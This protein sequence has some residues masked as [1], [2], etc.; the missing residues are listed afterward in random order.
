MKRNSLLT[1]VSFAMTALLSFAA[2]PFVAALDGAEGKEYDTFDTGRGELKITFLG[3]AT[4][5]LEF[6]GSLIYIDPVKQYGDFTKFPKANLILVTHE[7]GDHLDASSIAALKIDGTRIILNESSRKKLG[8]GDALE[9]GKTID[10]AGI[11]VLAVP[12]YNVTA[13]RSNNHPKERKDNGYI[14]TVGSLRIYVAGDTEPIPEME[15]FGRIDIAFLPMNLPYTM[16]PEQVAA[17]ARTLR[18]GI[19]YPYHFGT[20]DTSLLGTVLNNEQGIE[21]RLRKMQ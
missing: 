16:T 21:V 13:G 10:A 12:A 20:T 7:H 5:V 4:L 6:G 14:L 15:G 3:H 1:K 9:Y 17:A 2:A 11:S 18:P 19:L 8:S